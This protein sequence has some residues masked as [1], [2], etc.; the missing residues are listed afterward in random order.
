MCLCRS[1]AIMQRCWQ[2]RPEDRPE[3]SQLV[4][5]I[6]RQLMASLSDEVCRPMAHSALHSA[7]PFY[8]FTC[9]RILLCTHTL[10]CPFTHLHFYPHAHS[11]T[12]LRGSSLPNKRKKLKMFDRCHVSHKGHNSC[13]SSDQ[14]C[15]L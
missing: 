9:P 6:D 8:S 7:G 12:Q 14:N 13:L 3:F 5:Q 2:K 1:Y 15:L 11:P 10:I 4:C